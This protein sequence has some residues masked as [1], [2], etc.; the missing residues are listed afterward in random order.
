ML[1]LLLIRF[2]AH[3]NIFTQHSPKFY[4]SSAPIKTIFAMNQ[5]SGT[6]HGGKYIRPDERVRQE[7]RTT[8]KATDEEFP[9]L[10]TGKT[11][12]PS[13]VKITKKPLP[14]SA[15]VQTVKESPPPV[16]PVAKEQ[17]ASQEEMKS[18]PKRLVL[19]KSVGICPEMNG[20][21]EKS[22]RERLVY[23]GSDTEED[24][25]DIYWN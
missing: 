15:I 2:V 5:A 11:S 4:Q 8:Y 22:D 19:K 3:L 9:C 20:Q 12:K 7:P 1:I 6:T 16:K 17:G 23:V 13:S 21:E 25:E 10:P 24:D 18:C 14:W